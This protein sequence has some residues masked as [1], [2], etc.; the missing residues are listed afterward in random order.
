[1]T[2]SPQLV[3]V[4]AVHTHQIVRVTRSASAAEPSA[5]VRAVTPV[6]HVPTAL[7]AA[8]VLET[9]V[10]VELGGCHSAEVTGHLALAVFQFTTQLE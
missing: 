6:T 7:F 2:P 3:L 10:A 4:S 8:G 5:D 1:M 9:H